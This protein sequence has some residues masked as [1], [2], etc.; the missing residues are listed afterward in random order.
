MCYIN[1]EVNLISA[2]ARKQK[3]KLNNVQVLFDTC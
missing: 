2:D 1:E 3:Q